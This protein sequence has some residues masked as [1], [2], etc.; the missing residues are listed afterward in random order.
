[1]D[2]ENPNAQGQQTPAENGGASEQTN[3]PSGFQTRINELTAKYRETERA[4]QMRDQQ[5]TDL[6]SVMAQQVVH[7]P[8]VQAQ[9]QPEIDPEERT[10][11]EAVFSPYLKRLESMLS[12]VQQGLTT[13]QVEA[14]RQ[15]LP[16]EVAQRVEQ[17]TA[18]WQRKGILNNVATLDDAVN[19][20]YG[21]YARKRDTELAAKTAKGAFNGN[22]QHTLTANGAPSIQPAGIPRQHPADLSSR[23]ND[24]QLAYWDSIGAGDRPI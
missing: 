5:I 24:A 19:I 16:P 7:Q 18:N 4:L 13:T 22:G 12:Q 14:K 17:L 20:A 6:M 8:Q 21:E 11:M 2:L 3:E 9:A 23:S 10:K 15:G 1:M